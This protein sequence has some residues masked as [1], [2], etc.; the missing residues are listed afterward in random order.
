MVKIPNNLRQSLSKNRHF[1]LSQ[2]ATH[3][4]M[5]L[6][7]TSCKLDLITIFSLI[8][9][10]LMKNAHMIGKLL[11]MVQSIIKTIER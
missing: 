11:S 5:Q 3:K 9:P 2:S 7:K 8:P 4:D 1:S 6:Y 10:E